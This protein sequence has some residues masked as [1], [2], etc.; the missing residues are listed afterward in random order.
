MAAHKGTWTS[1]ASHLSPRSLLLLLSWCWL[2]VNGPLDL[3]V[4]ILDVFVGEMLNFLDITR[5]C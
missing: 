3:T 2:V 5:L 4:I 1:R